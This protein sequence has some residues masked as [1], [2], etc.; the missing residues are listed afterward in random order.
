MSDLN[1]AIDL[2][3]N[4]YESPKTTAMQGQRGIKP[5]A[6]YRSARLR[7][8]WAISL[9]A[10]MILLDIA[11]LYNDA[12][13][14]HVLDRAS[15]GLPVDMASA[16]AANARY[17]ATVLATLATYIFASVPFLMWMF[18][19][20]QNLPALGAAHLDHTPGM[21]V[22]WWFVP[23]ANLVKP[24]TAM[25]EIW[26][27]S[28]PKG[29]GEFARRGSLALVNVWWASYLLRN[30]GGYVLRLQSTDAIRRQSLPDLMSVTAAD[31]VFHVVS[32]VAAALAILVIQR[33]NAMQDERIDAIHNAVPVAEVV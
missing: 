13:Q 7:G 33:I 19:A 23:I 25:A 14:Y 20:Y 32:I 30:I 21:A 8:L 28:D 5:N 12:A 9:L 26:C 29:I 4:P 15:Q 6:V 10:V 24:Y 22:G 17:N 11:G 27:N 18:R 1:D 31:M 3:F 2:G 16:Q